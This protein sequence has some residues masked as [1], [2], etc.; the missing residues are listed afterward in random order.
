MKTI[1]IKEFTPPDKNSPFSKNRM[2]RVFLGNEQ[3]YYFTSQ[4]ACNNF[5]IKA[6]Q[7]FN[8]KFRHL[9]SLYAQVFIEYRKFYLLVESPEA[10][11]TDRQITDNFKRFESSL[12]FAVLAGGRPNGNYTAVSNLLKALRSLL[13]SCELIIDFYKARKHYENIYGLVFICE[14]LSIVDFQI[15]TFGIKTETNEDI[16]LLD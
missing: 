3:F 5:I 1:D 7:F 2:F 16:I 9:N 4:K 6:N 14:Q 10:E 12:S 15:N 11:K 13:A 8:G